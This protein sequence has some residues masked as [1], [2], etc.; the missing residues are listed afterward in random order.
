MYQSVA[1]W[2]KLEMLR[3]TDMEGDPADGFVS[4]GATQGPWKLV[5]SSC[6]TW[7]HLMYLCGLFGVWILVWIHRA[8]SCSTRPGPLCGN[9]GGMD[10]LQDDQVCHI[11]GWNGAHSVTPPQQPDPDEDREIHRCNWCH[12]LVCGTHQIR[13]DCSTDCGWTGTGRR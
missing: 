12:R 4:I 1:I 13:T 8:L 6:W 5:C 11:C 7:F 10:S 3:G 9:Y 2:L